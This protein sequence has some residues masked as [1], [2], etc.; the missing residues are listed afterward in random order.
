MLIA[1]RLACYLDNGKTVP[2]EPVANWLSNVS[3]HLA[4][5][6]IASFHRVTRVLIQALKD[7]EN[8]M[9]TAIVFNAPPEKLKQEREREL[10]QM[11]AQT[12]RAIAQAFFHTQKTDLLKYVDELLALSSDLRRQVVAIFAQR[13]NWFY[14]NNHE[15]S[16]KNLLSVLDSSDLGD[17]DAFWGGFF[18][19][20][21]VSQ[22]LFMRLKPHLIRLTREDGE[23]RRKHSQGLS[24]LILSGWGIVIEGTSDRCISNEEFRA[25]LVQADDEFRSHVLWLLGVW[26]RDDGEETRDKWTSLLPEFLRD[27][28]PRE[29]KGKLTGH[30]RVFVRIGAF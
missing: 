21:S 2:G 15:W 24:S 4:D 23:T 16:E 10:V 9:A 6:S 28:W 26:S 19:R 8:R 30:V 3:N 29:I 27:V 12:A 17:R 22:E 5:E 11:A 7:P 18:S 25:I 1:E 20:A 14:V 13:M